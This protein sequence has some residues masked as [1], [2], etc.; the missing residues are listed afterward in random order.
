MI[1]TALFLIACCGIACGGSALASDQAIRETARH[2]NLS[3]A[4][5]QTGIKRCDENQFALNLCAN[6]EFIKSDIELN[7]EYAKLIARKDERNVEQLRS[8]QRVWVRL[9]DLGCVYESSDL[10]GG[11]LRPAVKLACMRRM[12]D[13]R[14]EWMREMLSCT[15][16][17][18]ECRSASRVRK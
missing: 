14:I 3:I 4:D 5:V 10:E 13:E 2:S 16:V 9:R 17:A 18:G 11:S 6:Y 15:S 1:R 7:Q 12:T 8:A